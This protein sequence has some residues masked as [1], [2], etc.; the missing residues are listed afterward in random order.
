MKAIAIAATLLLAACSENLDRGPSC[1]A[2]PPPLT[3]QQ[4]QAQREAAIELTLMMDKDGCK[5][6]RF[7]DQGYYR[8]YT[9]CEGSTESMIRE[10]VGK[11]SRDVP[12][13][14]STKKLNR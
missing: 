13:T 9:T 12:E 10:R 3:P 14:I 7:K 6:Y 4:Y 1:C 2:P 5:L 8:Y 11:T